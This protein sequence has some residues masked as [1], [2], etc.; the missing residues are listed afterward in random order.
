MCLH[1]F[2]TQT[3]HYP[4]KNSTNYFFCWMR[5]DLFTKTFYICGE[6]LIKN[7]IMKKI[8][9]SLALA[10]MVILSACGGGGKDT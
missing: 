6:H 2:N 8:F 5:V 4:I 3:I 9:T 10:A 7:N 1:L